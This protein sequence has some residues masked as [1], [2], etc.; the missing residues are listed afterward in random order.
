[1]R[2]KQQKQSK[3]GATCAT[4]PEINLGASYEGMSIVMPPSAM[5]PSAPPINPNFD[6]KQTW[7]TPVQSKVDAK[8]N[9]QTDASL[10]SNK[11]MEPEE[12][13]G[14]TYEGI[15]IVPP[16]V[17]QNN[18]AFDVKQ[19][20]REPNPYPVI[21]NKIPELARALLDL[22]D[23]SV[24]IHE[25]QLC[26]I[27]NMPSG[28]TF[29]QQHSLS[30]LLGWM[31]NSYCAINEKVKRRALAEFSREKS[32]YHVSYH[33]YG[34]AESF[35]AGSLDQDPKYSIPRWFRI[36][37]PRTDV[38]T[39]VEIVEKLIC[40]ARDLP[41]KIAA[42]MWSSYISFFDHGLLRYDPDGYGY[43][44]FPDIAYEFRARDIWPEVTFDGVTGFNCDARRRRGR[45]LTLGELEQIEYH[46]RLMMAASNKSER[47]VLKNGI[48]TQ[49]RPIWY[50]NQ[51]H[52][53]SCFKPLIF[54]HL[55]GFFSTSIHYYF[56]I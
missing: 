36:G 53:A 13:L 30:C 26:S 5:P 20:M 1:V 11:Q 2:K 17:P 48:N 18:P 41:G 9:E 40:K 49:G 42:V 16:S 24:W 56:I 32:G 6:V 3:A 38:A 51:E 54:I 34:R 45:A 52:G 7:S 29:G 22:P 23:C 44:E 8:L 43:V 46:L 14:A 21:K 15:S 12:N 4:E 19:I 47:F 10:N 37:E 33:Y 50:A 31:E 28:N 39:Q 27:I 25:K 55:D 35:P